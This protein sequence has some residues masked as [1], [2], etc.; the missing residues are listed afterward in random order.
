MVRIVRL[1]YSPS[2]VNPIQGAN[3]VL[4]NGATVVNGVDNGQKM[5]NF[6]E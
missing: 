4:A 5:Y 3:T 1:L 6:I 2:N